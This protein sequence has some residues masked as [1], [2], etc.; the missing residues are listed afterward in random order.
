[1]VLERIE[2][3]FRNCTFHTRPTNQTS[4]QEGVHD[5]SHVRA[6]DVRLGAPAPDIDFEF[7]GY[8]LVFAGTTVDAINPALPIIKNI[9]SFP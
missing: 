4:C 1:M 2:H 7:Q 6:G 5:V 8:V 9:P 3:Y